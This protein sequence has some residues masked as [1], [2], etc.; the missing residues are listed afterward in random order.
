MEPTQLIDLYNM[1]IQMLDQNRIKRTLVVSLL[2][3]A[4]LSTIDFDTWSD[5][6]G[7]KYKFKTPFPKN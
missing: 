4:G 3:A 6:S 2:L 7:V 1:H 5:E